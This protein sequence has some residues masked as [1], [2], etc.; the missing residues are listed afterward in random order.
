[1]AVNRRKAIT[2]LIGFVLLTIVVTLVV[3]TSETA[4]KNRDIITHD[5]TFTGESEHWSAVLEVEGEEVFYEEEEVL[6][7]EEKADSKFMLGYKGPLEE[8]ASTS[9]LRYAYKTPTSASE[10]SRQYDVPPK[11]KTFTTRSNSLVDEDA[12]IEVTVE[13]DD[14]TEKFTLSSE[15]NAK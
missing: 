6:K 3:D 5:Y 2:A 14:M 15:N 7:H 10:T 13:W 8:F 1:M 9:E 11:E 12:V 4:S